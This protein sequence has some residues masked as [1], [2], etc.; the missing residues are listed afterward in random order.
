MQLK[1][2]IVNHSAEPPFSL[3]VPFWSFHSIEVL[4]INILNFAGTLSHCV[5]PTVKE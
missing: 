4:G 2:S 1:I 3:H 5:F